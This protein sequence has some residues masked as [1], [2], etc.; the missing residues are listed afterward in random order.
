MKKILRSR[1]GSSSILVILLL[2]VLVVFGIA[3]LTTAL[4]NLRLGQK[5]A[6]FSGS[7]YAVEGEAQRRYAQI[8]KTVCAVFDAGGDTALDMDAAL[9]RLDFR[10]DVQNEANHILI[11]YETWQQDRGISAALS[12]DPNDKNSLRIVK[13]QEI[14]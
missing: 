9:S 2:V 1:K 6:Q 4:S 14:Q 7:Y 10:T 11:V 12:L 8:D 3:A 13:W 5:A